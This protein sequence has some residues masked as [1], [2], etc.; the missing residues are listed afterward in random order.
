MADP[1]D[2]DL[3]MLEFG[4]DG[5]HAS[6]FAFGEKGWNDDFRE[7]VPLVPSAAELHVHMVLGLVSCGDFSLDELP[8]HA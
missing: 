4:K 1:S 7:E 6:A 8:D 3:A 2:A 5:L